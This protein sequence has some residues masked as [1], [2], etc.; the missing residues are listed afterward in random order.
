MGPMT[1]Y[2]RVLRV[3]ILVDGLLGLALLIY[4]SFLASGWSMAP[5]RARGRAVPDYS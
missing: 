4:P 1:N 3:V 5:R 2:E